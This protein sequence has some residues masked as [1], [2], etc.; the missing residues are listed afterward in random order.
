MHFS[1]DD[2]AVGKIITITAKGIISKRQILERMV[3]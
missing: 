2:Q 1:R 3:F